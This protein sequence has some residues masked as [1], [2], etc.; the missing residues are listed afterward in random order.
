M[1]APIGGVELGAGGRQVLRQGDLAGIALAADGRGDA[2]SAV[3]HRTA[4][5][6]G[7]AQ[8]DHSHQQ[9][10][11]HAAEDEL[12]AILPIATDQAEDKQSCTQTRREDA[13]GAAI[14]D[15]K[16]HHPQQHAAEDRH[17]GAEQKQA[18][19]ALLS[20]ADPQISL[21]H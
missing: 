14:A 8:T 12:S 15:P 20:K 13:E 2:R 4:H 17:A 5:G 18:P 10:R 6:S 1:G 9:G 16:G 3:D 21:Q 11:D 7:P 19:P